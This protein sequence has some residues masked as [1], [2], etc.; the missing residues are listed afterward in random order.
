MRVIEVSK[1]RRCLY[2]GLYYS[3]Q[4]VSS[5]LPCGPRNQSQG[6]TLRCVPEWRDT[7]CPETDW[8]FGPSARLVCKLTKLYVVYNSNMYL[9]CRLVESDEDL[10]SADQAIDRYV[11]DVK[12]LLGTTPLSTRNSESLLANWRAREKECSWRLVL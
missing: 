12:R 7:P 3:K 9:F 6:I 11:D 5:E 10:C 4:S 1:Y 2:G 8:R